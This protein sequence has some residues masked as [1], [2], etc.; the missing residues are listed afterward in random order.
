MLQAK[1]LTVIFWM[2]FLL[3]PVLPGRL[4]WRIIHSIFLITE[5]DTPEG[6]QYIIKA[7]DLKEQKEILSGLSAR[8]ICALY[9]YLSLYSNK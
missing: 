2:F 9:D 1:E 6:T 8:R 7:T 4:L 3:R 5:L